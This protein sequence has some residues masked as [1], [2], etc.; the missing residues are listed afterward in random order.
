MPNKTNTY[1]ATAL[2]L[3]QTKLGETDLILTLLST[4][5]EQIRAV[6]KG[7]RKPGSKIA[8]K[9]RLFSIVEGLFARGKNLDVLTDARLKETSFS[10][11]TDMIL[12]SFASCIA[13]VTR[14]A[15]YPENIDP[16]L[17]GST[18]RAFQA[19]EYAREDQR[20]EAILLAAHTFKLL[21]H[22][23]WHP[24]GLPKAKGVPELLEKM[25]EA[26]DKTPVNDEIFSAAR[27][28][29]IPVEKGGSFTESYAHSYADPYTE[30]EF[31]SSTFPAL[32][33]YVLKATYDEIEKNLFAFDLKKLLSERDVKDLLFLSHSWATTQLDTRLKSFEYL[34]K[35]L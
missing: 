11:E 16:F 14:L 2:V 28:G 23:G 1:H 35:I 20:K 31:V 22:E 21:S 3:S 33:S 26:R 17:W 24:T 4:T 5:G 10:F 32:I 9:T 12:L 18:V 34:E 30:Q 29:F 27:G 25:S 8:G 6:A 7:G 13:S 19:L 15:T